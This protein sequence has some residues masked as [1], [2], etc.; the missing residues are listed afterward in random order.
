VRPYFRDRR[1]TIY[2]GDALTVLS[3]LDVLVDVVIADPPYS[4][5]GRTSAERTRM[6]TSTKY[7][8][9]DAK[10]QLPDFTGDSRDQH[11]HAHWCALWLAAA[12]RLT[13]PGGVCFVWT[14][15]RQ[16]A[17]T[18]DALQAGGWVWRGVVIWRKTAGRP[19]KGRF[20]LDSE[21]AVWGSNGDMPIH[22]P[23]YP[24]SVVSATPPRQR[25]HIA[26]KPESVYE[27][28]L[29]IAPPASLVLDPF[30][31]SGS[32]IAAA[33]AGGHQAIGIDLDE[34]YCAMA[35]DRVRGGR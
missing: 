1:A 31:G 14:D 8:S 15:W 30:T 5:G 19:V 27:H 22:Q 18:S 35:A 20:K 34:R 3:Q 13:R 32:A 25:T 2:H 16:L 17:A 23:V 12:L 10:R 7:V 9:S 29:S 4:S 24:S 28:M 26:Q 6:S 21:F 33:I 11:G